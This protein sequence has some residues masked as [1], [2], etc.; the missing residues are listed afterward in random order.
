MSRQDLM[1]S[2]GRA[3]HDSGGEKHILLDNGLIPNAPMYLKMILKI[4]QLLKTT[5][6]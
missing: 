3:S 2:L 5:G 6:S 4:K 1:L